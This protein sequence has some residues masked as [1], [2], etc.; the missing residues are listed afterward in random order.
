MHADW[1]KDR[2]NWQTIADIAAKSPP[3]AEIVQ[4][5]RELRSHFPL[6]TLLT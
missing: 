6:E 3:L 5:C 4:T 2:R 1:Q